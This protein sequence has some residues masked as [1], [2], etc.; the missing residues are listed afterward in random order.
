[1]YSPYR[2]CLIKAGLEREI[3]YGLADFL[4]KEKTDDWQIINF[5]NLPKKNLFVTAFSIALAENG[6]SPHAED[7]YE[8]I[9]L[10]FSPFPDSDVYFRSFK[11]TFRE[12][13]KRHI[14]NMN[15]DG[16]FEIVL[17]QNPHQDIE[18]C[19]DDYYDIYARSWK[20]QENDPLF[21]RHLAQYLSEKGGLRL[22]ILYLYESVNNSQAQGFVAPLPS[23]QSSVQPDHP[24]PLK[25]IPIAANF[26]ILR[27]EKAY[28]LKTSYR[29]DYAKYGP[30]IV[31]IWF[32]YKYLMDVEHVKSVDLQR[33][34]EDW[35]IKFGGMINEMRFQLMIG[36][37]QKPLARLDLMLRVNLVPVLRRLKHK[38]IMQW[39]KVFKRSGAQQVKQ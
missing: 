3:A 7:Q 22:F 31:S 30:G 28:F 29:E 13:I 26:F 17:V 33:G 34:Y 16:G 37:P 36:N 14:N 23:Y 32:S 38:M 8:N 18:R 27:G 1:M 2:G 4:I 25:G 39:A 10:D 6:M 9:I 15:R 35:K 11:K 24:V 21:H 19:M 20:K 12:P 5:E